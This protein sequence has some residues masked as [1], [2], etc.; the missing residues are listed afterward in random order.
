MIQHPAFPVEPWALREVDLDL[1]MLAQS[2]SLFALAN[3][4]V[5][6][7]GNLDEGE[8]HGLLGTDLAGF[9]E[10]RPL[11]YAKAGYG[12][13]EAGQTVVNATVGKIVRLLIED[14]PFDIRYGE[15]RSHERLGH[16][17]AAGLSN[18]W[19]YRTRRVQRSRQQQRVHQP[20]GPA[21]PPRRRRQRGASPGAC[22]RTR[23]RSR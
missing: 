18:P 17:D 7:R 21:E 23:R 8:P 20:H 2:E 15:L 4:H 6:L 13:P 3:G 9:Y 1:E 11:P 19:R 14:E 16:Y 5:G 10:S 22:R 12:Y